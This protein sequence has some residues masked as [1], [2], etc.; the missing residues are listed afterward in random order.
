MQ[1]QYRALR[2]RDAELN[3]Q[4]ARFDAALNNM[5]QALCM[6]SAERRL[7]VCNTRFIELFGLDEDFVGPA[8]T[9]D[10]LFARHGRRAGASMPRCSARSVRPAALL[11]EAAAGDLLRE[12]PDGRAIA[13]SHQPMA[14]GG[15][16]ATYEDI[17]DRRRV[18]ARITFLAHHDVLTGLP[19]RLLFQERMD[20]ALATAAGRGAA[21]RA[22]L[23]RPR[24]LQERQRHAGPSGRATRCCGRSRGG[25][26]IACGR[27]T[28]WR[29]WAAT[30]SPSCRRRAASR[31][32]PR[33]W[34]SAWS[35]WSARPTSCPATAP[36]SASASASRWP[37]CRARRPRRVSGTAM[38]RPPTSC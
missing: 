14:D 19:N 8:A 33:P 30:N 31:R 38:P 17:T 21:P 36:R 2:P 20:E 26:A 34:R 9:I 37:A 5:S 27:A 1:Q 29:G 28:W 15:W 22:A 32:M 16:V 13:V 10:S 24:P 12:G 18:E 35:R 7:I 3:A 23:P 4:N 11:A 25:C 6:F